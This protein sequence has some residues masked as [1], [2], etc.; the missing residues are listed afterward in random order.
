M[1]ALFGEKAAL[2]R[3]K[4]RGIDE[5]QVSPS[6]KDPADEMT[7]DMILEKIRKREMIIKDKKPKEGSEFDIDTYLDTEMEE[8]NY[9]LKNNKLT[10][11]LPNLIWAFKSCM[12]AVLFR[13]IIKFDKETN[14]FSMKKLKDAT[15]MIGC[16]GRHMPLF[17][18]FD[19]NRIPCD[20][21]SI[22]D[23]GEK[24]VQILLRADPSSQDANSLIEL[25]KKAAFQSRSEG[26]DGT[27]SIL[28][29]WS[30]PITI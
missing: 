20:K 15:Y 2:N 22:H 4:T 11:D 28:T 19:N 1:T 30:A 24:E 25:I 9:F 27:I 17:I 5:T 18:S 13:P 26:W 21:W 6:T 8:C 14:S 7:G 29:I 16:F 12:K 10:T 3:V 23:I